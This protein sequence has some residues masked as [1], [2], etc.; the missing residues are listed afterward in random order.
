MTRNDQQGQTRTLIRAVAASQSTPATS[1]TPT[2]H[3]QQST[4]TTYE[5]K[6]K[7][8][9]VKNKSRFKVNKKRNLERSCKSERVSHYFSLMVI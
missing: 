5:L 8:N 6:M 2:K 3:R 4:E 7:V 1:V 9:R